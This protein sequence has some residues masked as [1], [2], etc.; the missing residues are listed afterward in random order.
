[1]QKQIANK[2]KV[3]QTLVKVYPEE[4]SRPV[5]PLTTHIIFLVLVVFQEC[6]NTI[7]DKESKGKHP[8]QLWKLKSYLWEKKKQKRQAG[9]EN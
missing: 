4:I 3:Q 5:S 2:I 8:G 9:N 6:D 1:M 7:V